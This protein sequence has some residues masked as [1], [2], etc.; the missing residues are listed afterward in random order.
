MR[1]GGAKLTRIKNN[2]SA[3][4]KGGENSNFVW[5]NDK[6]VVQMF[7]KKGKTEKNSSSEKGG[8]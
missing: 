7:G 4:A 1:G 6:H 5:S 8:G 3:R 2:I